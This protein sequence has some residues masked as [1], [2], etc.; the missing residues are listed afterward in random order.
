MGHDVVADGPIF[1][2]TQIHKLEFPPKYPVV[3]LPGLPGFEFM[4]PFPYWL[5]IR[6]DL[7][8]HGIFQ[9]KKDP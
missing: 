8:S 4:G 7:E 3:F 1:P 5:G 9:L 6:E 2:P